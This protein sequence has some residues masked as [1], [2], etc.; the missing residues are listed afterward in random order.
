ME[1]QKKK[2]VLRLARA[3]W[4]PDTC[5]TDAILS[6]SQSPGPKTPSLLLI[7]H[8]EGTQPGDGEEVMTTTRHPSQLER[9]WR[10]SR[11]VWAG[12]WGGSPPPP[13]TAVSLWGR[14]APD[15]LR[16]RPPAESSEANTH[17]APPRL[18]DKLSRACRLHTAWVSATVH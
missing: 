18:R 7:A 10:W 12:P 3:V 8:Q 16:A 6:R 9:G 5:K 15:T 13:G 2:M 4:H 17:F 1:K 11:A 14:Y